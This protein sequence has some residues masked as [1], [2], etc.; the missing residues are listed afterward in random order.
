MALTDQLASLAARA[1]QAEMRAAE[2]QR[3]AANDLEADVATAR[4]SVQAQAQRLR[5][6]TEAGRDKISDWWTDV[7]KYVGAVHDRIDEANAKLDLAQAQ[8]AAETAESDA[9]YAIAYAYAAIE[10]AEYSVLHAE[11]ARTKADELE[12]GAHATA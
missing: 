7:Q 9:L 11:F 6:T 1:K 8:R 12:A 10:Q 2:A 4:A 5:E 3:K